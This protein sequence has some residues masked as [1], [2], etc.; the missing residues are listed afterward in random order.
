MAAFDAVRGLTKFATS[1]LQAVERHN[2]AL[3]KDH[4][5]NKRRDRFFLEVSDSNFDN[6][7]ETLMVPPLWYRCLRWIK[8]QIIGGAAEA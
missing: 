2:K 1:T 6:L 8:W 3:F 5:I 4:R 7:V